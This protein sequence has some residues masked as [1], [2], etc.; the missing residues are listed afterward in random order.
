LIE[1][2]C[3]AIFTLELF[4]HMYVHGIPVLCHKKQRKAFIF[5]ICLVGLSW[6]DMLMSALASG[7]S[8][9]LAKMLRIVRMTKVLRLLRVV[10][11]LG[12]LRV[13][14]MMIVHSLQSLFWLF[15]LLVLLLYIAATILTQGAT[16]YL[17]FGAGLGADQ[18]DDVQEAYGSL[19]RTMYTLFLAMSGGVSWGEVAAPMARVHT[20]FFVIFLIYIFFTL[21]SVLNIVTGVFVD[22]AIQ[23]AQRDRGV[24]MEKQRQA[25][26]STKQ[27]VL[28]LL[29]EIDTDKTGIISRDELTQSLESDNVK[30]YF[31]ALSIDTDNVA[32]LMDLL[33]ADGDGAIDISEFVDGCQRLKGE[34]KSFDI[35]MLMMQ[36]RQVL[37]TML[38]YMASK[39]FLSSD[40]TAHA[41]QSSSTGQ[42]SSG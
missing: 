22:S 11:K 9:S 28:S 33:D 13:M 4:L 29:E 17:R 32:Q 27:H 30:D 26:L 8:M 5:D 7:D 41:L 21:F 12:E 10:N 15:W 37:K 42:L 3:S 19:F 2:V 14:A 18:G 31:N 16:E 25:A 39:G 40:S 36:N 1:Y 24:L 6:F 35:H 20:A 34:A 38:D 23:A